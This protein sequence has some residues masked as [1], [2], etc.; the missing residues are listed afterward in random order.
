MPQALRSKL[1]NYALADGYNPIACQ[2]SSSLAFTAPTGL[3]VPAGRSITV[4]ASLYAFYGSSTLACADATGVTTSK[5]SVTRTGCSYTITAQATATGTASFTV[6]YT[7]AAQTLNGAFTVAIGPASNI[8]FTSPV[9]LIVATSASL[10]VYAADYATDGDYAISCAD[11]T[12]IDSKI[13]VQRTLCRYTVTAGTQLGRASFTVPYTSAG[14][15]TYNGTINIAIGPESR[16]LFTAPTGLKVARN[17]TLVIDA[18]RYVTEQNSV[19]TI[20]CLDAIGVDT[21]RLTAVSRSTSGNGCSYTIDPIDTLSPSL[22]GDT[23]FTIPYRSSSGRNARRTITV[24]IGPDSNLTF[25]DPGTFTVGRNRTLVIDAVRNRIIGENSAYTVSCGDATGV[26]AARMSVSRSGC[27]FTVDPV[28]TL[29]ATAPVG[30]PT[31]ATQGDTTFSVA[32]TSTGGAT[33]TGTFTVNIGPDSE[34]MGPA[35][36]PT[37]NIGRNHMLRINALDFDNN[38]AGDGTIDFTDGSYSILCEGPSEVETSKIDVTFSSTNSCLYTAEFFL[39]LGPAT[40]KVEF[41]STGGHRLTRT[42]TV[43]VGPQSVITFTAPTGL[44]VARDRTLEIDALDYVAERNPRTDSNPDGYTITCGDA[45]GLDNTK[46][47]SVTRS[48]SGDGC[49][50]TVD[51]VDTFVPASNSER[52]TTFSVPYTS[53][54]GD[55][56]TGTFTVNV[57]GNHD[58]DIVFAEPPPRNLYLV[59]GGSLTLNALDYDF[60]AKSDGGDDVADGGYTVSC[61]TITESPASALISLGAQSDGSCSI[62]I[63][64]GSGTGTATISVPYISSGGDIDS[65]TFTVAVSNIAYDAPTDLSVVVGRTIFVLVSSYV[66]D[67]SNTITCEA[68]PTGIDSNKLTSVVRPGGILAGCYFA[69]TAAL[70]AADEKA[71]FTVPV[72]SGGGSALDVIIQV[73]INPVSNISV[74]GTPA[75]LNVSRNRT[76]EIDALDFDGDGTDEVTDSSYT[77]SCGDATGVDA[78]K[79]AVSHTASSCAFTVD[80]VD[81]LDLSVTGNNSTTFTVP[82]TSS[83]GTTTSVTFTVNI[84]TDSTI[85]FTPPAS[86]PAIAASRTRTID[87]SSYAADGSYTISCGTITESSALISLGAQ[88]GCSI[89]ITAGSTPNQTANITIPYISSG[90]HTLSATL[91]LDVGAASSIIFTAPT[92]LKVGINRTQTIDALDYATD[93]GYTITCGTATGVDTTKLVS[94]VRDISGNGCGYT[95]TPISTLTQSQQGSASFTVP[96]TSDGGDTE[97]AMFSITVGPTSTITFTAPSALLV[98][99]NRTLVVDVSSYAVEANPTNYAISCG[100]AT[101]IDTVELQSVT[102]T[103]SSCTFTINPKNVAGSASFT[104]PYTSEG[105]HSVAGAISVTVGPD[106]N[107]VYT[108]PS[109]LTVGRNRT[110]VIDASDHFTEDSAYTVTCGDATGVDTYTDANS[111]VVPKMAVTHTGSSCIFTV[112][113]VDDLPDG[114]QGDATFSVAFTSTGGATASGTFTVNIGPDSTITYT[115]P[116]GLTVGRNRTLSI[117]ASGYVSEAD[118]NNTITCGDATSIDTTRLASVTR[119]ANTCSFTITP[120]STL[121]SSLQ[122]TNA[123][124]TV[125][126]ASSG[127]ATANGIIS[128]KVGPDSSMTFTAPT[129]LTVGR[130][131]TLVIDAL[132]AI[133][134]ENAAYTVSCADATSVDA[135]KMTVTRSSS[136]DGCSFTVDP[137]DSLVQAS[138]GDST[139]SVAFTST[140]GATASGTFTVNIGPDSTI[141]YTA[142]TGLTVGRNRTL[143]IDALAAISGENAAYTVSCADA[144]GVDASKMTV[145]RSSSGDGCSF[146]VDPVDSLATG[147]QG[148]TTFSVAFTSTGGATASGTFTVNIGPDS[149]ITYTAPTG[150]QIGRNQTL[151]IDASDYVSE[152]SNTY[153][154]SCSDASNLTGGRL[155]SVARTANTCDYTITPNTS[156]SSGAASFTITYTSNGGHSVAAVISLRVGPNSQI[157]LNTPPTS[158][159]GSLL[160]GRNR[161]LTIDASAYATETTGSGYTITCGDATS[162]DTTRLASVTR[163]ANTCSFTI[164]PISTLSSSLQTTNASFTVPYSSSGGATA[165]GIISVKVGPDSSMTFTAPTGL[166]VGRNRTLVIDA[167]AAISGENAAYT[168]S[169]ADA[170]S[171]DASKMTVTRSSSGDGCS[172]TVDPVDSLVQASQGDSTF[173]VAFTSTGGATAS[174]T[175]TVNI[176]P[177]STITYTAPTG[178]TVGRNRTLVI[179][180]LAA[181]SGENAAYTVSCADATGVDASKMAVTRSSSGDGCSFT[182]DPVDSLATGS[183]GDTTFSV[184]FTSTGGATASGTFTVNIGPDS[185]IVYTAPSGLTVGRNRT[186]VIDAS[187]HFTEDSAYTVTCGDATGVDTYTDANSDVVPKMAVT[188]TGSSCTFT[189]DPV[190]DLPD[191]SQGDATFS[192][193]FTSTGG[194]TA[195]G[196]FTVNIGPDS[197]ITYTAPTGLTVGRNRTLVIDALAAISGEN[198]AYTVSCADATG[199]DASK[200]TVTRSSSGDGCSFTVDPVDSL[201]TGSQGDTTFSVAFTSTGGATASGTFTVNIGPDS[202]ITYTAPTGLQIGRNQTLE[203]DASDYVSEAS[204]TYTIS[205]SDASNLT[206]GRLS[207]VA[208]TANTCDYTITP[209]TSASSGAASFTITY[210]SNGGHSVAAVISLRVGPNSQITLNT[211]PTSGAG[212]LL[213]GRNRTLTIDASAYATE[214]TGSGYTITCGDATSIDT[215]RLASVTRTANT[216][217]FTITPISTLSSSLQT[218]NASFTVPYSSSGGATANGIISVKVGPD[219]SMTFTAPT[220]LKVGRNRTLVIDASAAISGEDAAYAISCGDATG[221]DASKMTVAHI[222]SS[223]S[224][225]VDP[226]DSLVQASQGD[227]TFSV[228][229]SSTGGA[230]ASGTFTVNI[231]PDSTISYT[232]PGTL[233]VGRNRT[234][235]IDASSYVSDGS[236]TIACADATGVDTT[237]LTSV[238]RSADTCTF[239][240]DPVDALAQANQGDTTFSVVFTSE[241]GHIITRTITVNVGPDSALTFTAPGTFTLGRNRTLVIDALA[242][243]S[244]ENAAYTVTCADATGVDASKMTVTRSSGCS[245]TVDPVDSL[246]VGSQGDTTFSVAFSSTGGAT[247]SGTFTVNIGPDSNMTF[248]APT[249]LKVGRNRTLVIE[250]LDAISGENSAYT[251]TCADATG[252]DATKMTVT[253]SS[254][255][256]GCSFTV[257]PVDSLVVGSQGDTTFSVAYTSTGGATASGTYTVNIGPDSTITYTAPTG[258][259]IGRNL[260]LTI[261]ASDYVSE[262]GSSYTITC[263]DARNLTGGRL[264]SVART[265]NTCSYTITPNTSASTG[266]ASFTITYTSTGGHSL[267]AVIS[268]RVGP[269]SAITLNLPPTTGAGSLLT[270]RNRPLV[271]DAGSYASETSGS[272]YTI[273]C[274][275]ATSID[276]TRLASVT[277]TGSSCTFTVTPISTLSTSLQ[278]TAATFTVPYVS[279]GGATA[280]GTISVKIGPDSTMTFTAPTGLKVGRN[281]TLVIDASAAISGEDAAYA[282]SCGDA[283]GVDASKMTVAHIGSSCSFTVDPVDSLVQASQGDTTFSV[284]FSS[285]G[286]A[287]ASGTFTVNI[288]PD[289]TISYT[290]PGTLTVGR[291]RTLEIDASSYVSDGSYTIACA[292]ATGVDTTK[293]TSVSRSANTCTFTIDPVD[294]LAQANQGDTTFSVVFTSEG[295]HI[296]TRTITVNVGPDSA[297]TFTAPG[298]FT[299]GRN[300]TLVIDALAAISGENAAYTVTCGDATGVDASKMT[301]T[302][303]SGCSFTVDPV[304]SLATGSQGDTTFSVA[305][306][307]TGGATASGTFTVNIGPDS[308]MTFTAPTG[309]KVGRNRT[310]VIEALDAISGEDSAYTV[311]CADATGVD[312]TKM[313]VTRSSTGDGCSFTVD[314]VDSLAV[315]S[316]G[317]TT[318][319]VAYTSTGGAT[320]SGTYTVN[321]GP[322]STISYTAPTGLQIGRNLTLTIDA[323]DYVSEAG[324]SYTITCSDARNLTGGRLASV[325]R[326]ANTCSYT[327]TPNT[328]ASTGNA[329]FTIT[330]T[331]TGGH[332]IVRVISLRVGPNSAITFTAPPTTGAGRLLTGRN[333]A[334]VVDAG[335]YASETSGSGYTI[336][337]GDATSIDTTRLASVTHTGSSCTFTVTPISTL[338]TSLQTTNAAFTVPYT[339]SGGATANGIISVKIGPDSTMTFT[340]PTGLKVG[341]NRTLEID[342][343]A[344]ISGEDADYA[345]SCGDATGVDASKMEVAHIG[346]SC[347]FTVDPVNNLASGSQGDTTFSVPFTS[348]GGATASGTFTVNIGPDSTITYSTPGTLTVGRNRTLTIDAS[349]YVSEVSGSGHT[350]TCSDAAGV[351]STKLTSV[352]RTA[353]S[354]SFIITPVSSLSQ[355]LQGDTTFTIT[356]TSDGGHSITRTITVNVGPDSTIVFTPPASNLAI[357]ASR[358][359]TIDVSS[360]AADGSYTIT[361]GTITESDPDITLG[362]QTGCSIEITAGST[363]SQTADITIPYRSSGGHTLSSA[364]TLDVGAASSIVFTAPTSLKVGT[365]RTQTIDASDYATDGGY[366]ITCGTAT[367]TAANVPTTGTVALT[368]VVRDTSGN[369][370]GYTIT[371]TAT[372]GTATFTIP[373]T[374]AGGDTANGNISIT[375]GPP[376]TISYSSPGTLRVGRNQ[377]LEIDAS[378]Y[379]SDNSAYTITCADATGVVATRMAVTRTAN[380]CTF[381][382]DPVDALTPANQGVTTFTIPFTSDGGHSITGTVTVNIGPDSALT[383]TAPSTFTLGRNRTLVIDAL[384]AISGENA[385]YTVTCADATGVDADKITVTRSSSGDGCSFTVDPVDSLVQASQGDTTFSVAYTSTGGATASGTYT[386]NI[387]PDSTI[388]Y[389]AP[390]GLQIGRNLTL[391]IDASDY[392]TEAGSSYTITCSDARNL[393]GGRLASV[394]RT[395][396]TCDYTITPNTSASTGNASFTITYTS[397]GGHSLAAVISLRVGPN[398]AITLNLPPTTGAGSLLTGRNRPLVVDAGSYASETSGSGYTITCGDATSIDTTRLTS[399]THTGSS[400]SFTVTPIST[401]SSTL[402]ATNATFTV[403]Y[404]S[405]G[406]ATANGII[407]VKI[408]PD[409]TMTFTAPTGLK[410]GRN[411]T[412]EIDA[413][414]AISGEDAAYA[415]SCGDATSVDAS[416]MEVA[417]IG[418]SCTF[419]VDPVNNLASGSQGDTTFSVA[420]T[421]TGGATASGTFTVNIG[422]DSTITY[423]A[424]GTLTVGRNRTLTIDASDYVSEVSGSGHTITCS[425]AAGVDN[426]KLTSV[427]RTAN[428]CSFI[429]TPVSSLSQSLQGD[430]TFT[431]TF[432]SDGGHSITRTITVNVGPDSTI[433]FTPPAS[434]LAIAASRTRTIDVSGYA[435]DGSYTISCGSITESD[436]DITLGSQTGCSIEITAGSTPSQTA[437]ITIPYR[438]S[439]GH[440]LSSTLTLD[441]GA[442]STIVFTAPTGLKVGTN[443]TQTIDALD[444]AS[445]GGYTITC[446]IATNTAANVPTSGTVALTSVVRDAS[447]N[448]CGYTITP[449]ATQGTAT[450]TIPYTSAGG[451]TAN[452]NISITAGPPSTISYTAPGTLRVG[453]NLT[454]EI[455]ASGYVSDNSAYTI[456]CADATGVD[457]TKMTVTRTANSCTFT[458]DPVDS[459]APANQGS[460]SFSV[461]FTSDGG[462]SITRTITVNIG[463][464]S[465]LTFNDPG[466]FKLGRNRTLVIDALAATSGENAAYTVTCA[467]ATGV[468]ANKM[469]VTRSSTGDG[470]SFTVDP[471]DSLVQAS[472]GDTTFSVAFTSTGGA[473]ASGT[474]TINIGPDSTITYTA[475]TGL[476]VG[477]NRTLEID[478]SSYVSDNSAYTITCAD[479]TGVDATKMTVTRTANSCTFTIDPVDTL[480]QA[481]QGDTTFSITF[482]SDGGATATGSVTVNIGPDSTITFTAPTGLKTGRNRSL[483]LN[484]LDYV[485]YNSAYTVT[486]ADATAMDMTRIMGIARSSSGN[487]CAYTVT[488]ISTLAQSQQGD[489][490]FNV[491]FTSTGGATATGTFTINI[492]PDSTITFTAP[493]GLKVGRNR[494]LTINASDYVRETSGSGYTISCGDATGLHSSIDFIRRTGCAFTITP[495]STLTPAQQGDATFAIP[496]SS[497]GGHS[498]S[499][500]ITVN[501]GP[502]STITYTSPG[503]LRVAR[504]RTLTIDASS[505]VREVSGS[506]HTITCS[507]AAGADSNKMAVSRTANTCSFTIDPVDSLAPANQ[508]ATTFSITFTSDGG[509]SITRTITVNIGPDSALTFTD[510][511]TFTLGRNR[512]LVI[513]ALAATSGENAAYT[514][515][516]ADA[517]GVD[518]NKMTVTR[519]SSGDGCSFTVDPVDS[520]ATGS[521]GDTTFTVAFTSTG[522]ATASGTFTINIGPDSTITTNIPPATGANRLLVGRNLTLEIDASGYATEAS[523]TYTISCSDARNVHSRLT[524]V[525]R[526]ANTCSY[527]IDPVDSTSTGAATFVITFTS[528]GGHSVDRTITVNV[529][530]NSQ[531][532][533]TAPTGLK[534]GRN[535]TLEI[536]ALA[537]IS[538]ENSAY[539]VTCADATAIDMNRITG[540]ARSSSGN[541]CTYM[542]TPHSTLAQSL[543]GDATFNVVF[544]STGGATVTGTFTVNVGPDSTITYTAPTGLKVGRNRTLTIN[545]ASYA[546]DGSY[547]ISCGDATGLH[548]S[549]D[550]IRRTGCFFTITPISTLTPAQQGDAT[551]A[552]PFSSDGGHSISRTITV[553][554]GPDSEITYTAPTGSAIPIIPISTTRT[555]DVSSYAKEILNSGYTLS[556]GDASGIDSK[557]VSATHT[558]SSCSFEITTGSSQ[559]ASGFTTLYSS[560]GGHTRSARIPLQVGPASNIGF[561]APS[562]LSVNV[563]QTLTVDASDYV[564]DGPYSFTCA[565]AS[566]IS[567]SLASVLRATGTCRYTITPGSSTGTGTFSVAYTSSGGTTATQTISVTIN[568]QSRIS[569]TAPT[570]LTVAAGRAIT[571]DASSAVDTGYTVSCGAATNRHSRIASISRTGC[572]YRVN[573]G[574]TPGPA[575]FTIPFTSTGG[576]TLNVQIS[577]TIGPRSNIVFNAPTGLSVQIGQTLTID[578]SDYAADGTYTIT[579]ADAT[580]VSVLLA[581]VARTANT[582]NY[583]ITP[584]SSTGNSGF[585]VPYTSSGGATRN[586]RVNL[587]VTPTSNIVF[588][589]PTDLEIGAGSTRTINLSSYATDGPYSITC[590]NAT[591]AEPAKLTAIDRNGCDFRITAAAGA[592]QGD[593][594]FA[595]TYTSSGGDTH[596]ATFTIRIGPA[597]SIVFTAPDTNPVIRAT[598]TATIDVGQ[599]A[600]D[601]DYTITCGAASRVSSRIASISNNGCSYR[602]RAGVLLGQATFTVAYSSSGGDTLDAE[603]AITIIAPPSRPVAAAP[604]VSGADPNEVDLPVVEL[605]APE[606]DG[607]GLRWVTFT[608]DRGGTT[609]LHIRSAM[610]LSP[611]RS[612]YFWSTRTQSWTRITNINQRLSAGTI[613]AF[614]TE[615]AISEERIRASNLGGSTQQASL[616]QGWNLISLP[617]SVGELD[618]G[619]SLLDNSLIDCTNR[620]GVLIIAN[621]RP[622]SDTWHISLPCHPQLEARLIASEDASFDVLT[623]IEPGDFTFLF[624]QAPLGITV[625]WDEDTLRYLPS[626]RV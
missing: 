407:S 36:I 140:G 471:V 276:T 157:T 177:D 472:Q 192:V 359:R 81:S 85:V 45:T 310:L 368:S 314:P 427:T 341:R 28:D 444:Y 301:V 500:T 344:A 230:T 58:S 369:G 519:S 241:G 183:Q 318:F 593:T 452:G 558:G 18:S 10:T 478:A 564:T 606:P 579:C 302:R 466:T 135:S 475:P 136:G 426:T 217:S 386:I 617:A 453:R 309:L 231:G 614:Q 304:D 190:D 418:S 5:I 59:P 391:T 399:V 437:D 325:A 206:G 458:I 331:S 39:T 220:G 608:V 336:T 92:G 594:T 335:S 601:G 316:Q 103:G 532:T 114:S 534:V 401:L 613:V 410:V 497:D 540:I 3:Q 411:R 298:T 578:A 188:H 449:T 592:A 19:F 443:R 209:N 307:S 553:N 87:V 423:T 91:T 367:N 326:T 332:S 66:S 514:V 589:A 397:T 158:G 461:V 262:A 285:T 88:N 591:A 460:T 128:V 214:T 242:A 312:A 226:V 180:A 587:A 299:L 121:S 77:I 46:L 167:L 1:G 268:L 615:G 228:A 518:A 545:A 264:T 539:T 538:G 598:T 610:G 57:G 146:T 31:A 495:I 72:T 487:G 520:L 170:T 340:A 186:L 130:N 189:V 381:T 470:C 99:K 120:I 338:S 111:D 509:H 526:T 525:A 479:A 356:F 14:G 473:T 117:D 385:A 159:A 339:S 35:T 491:V 123:T 533:F 297:L 22:Q 284:A 574:G 445:D 582:C 597:S 150:L 172:F 122:T 48:S 609:G 513:D 626:T 156:A 222:G 573:A 80:P 270:G 293:L 465:A 201:A 353:N 282:I 394:A 24:N 459:L 283:T 600:E 607:L 404:T 246:V 116:T 530:P 618:S 265:A 129:G 179:D 546:S 237:K 450:F 590:G 144:T 63:T 560:T 109:G 232:D 78:N 13:T 193:A 362:A 17:F 498:I 388:T 152:A 21:T 89:E 166:T 30:D 355:S 141:T 612:I 447:G 145:T 624:Y 419:T 327:I 194:A 556:C 151:E 249:G 308:S 603:I 566:S 289:S 56:A 343:S 258:L 421:S 52:A 541:G 334:L 323:S 138:Q 441:V 313:T 575:S 510:P 53:S 398:S 213:T 229:F 476:K 516:C 215:T 584:G 254:T 182:V 527:T 522:G 492:G 561:S 322:D 98:A 588:I 602:I 493:T 133:S 521:Q 247:A 502:D 251:V 273:S 412:L 290:S 203:I 303:S 49:T 227:T 161:T 320:A 413:A 196:T 535:R 467:D 20:S 171:V 400:C 483:T 486:C 267:A 348:T 477:R 474:F 544:T 257:D 255:G 489:A 148:D 175:F 531:I 317:D 84:S 173:S 34:I 143:V 278:T 164:T 176:G 153:T 382:I 71:T 501:I 448:G 221:V 346:S 16:V 490:T 199:V 387:G 163:T 207:S 550:F 11:A 15:N 599:Y 62:E 73:K 568:P 352:T 96:L 321:I 275:D 438:S 380:S 330:Y 244:G 511:G 70:T 393:T 55:T 365:N 102:H 118:S 197:T 260:T 432:T 195:S 149:T 469:T 243:I 208:R 567:S 499:R 604:T 95:I 392:A 485:T 605:E 350:I 38:G 165:N 366:T 67:G 296:I 37:F 361:C 256:D 415:I 577:I 455:D 565:D 184:A 563:G 420:F 456:T 557:L 324:S 33:A 90:G 292:D 266:N 494:T 160:T 395:A 154:I 439:G 422:P 115:A 436:P 536:K 223:C 622:G 68:A 416:K 64:A 295:G 621:Q 281:R 583:T 529:G 616:G 252:V 430:T 555:I 311:T 619:N 481:N 107:I 396:N 409:S 360:Y 581:S 142:P 126:Y 269:N 259:Q 424:P 383:F 372:Q 263:S 572:S 274:G 137:V 155:S 482:T 97:N 288:G 108:A 216:C 168:V 205:C 198:A 623:A 357:A 333:R 291:N 523:N 74:S 200:M 503:T 440:T 250:A 434:N 76:L 235:E 349:D 347:S 547:T 384:A 496:F 240:I 504:N 506:G 224:F 552:I 435:A 50:F 508:G 389:N 611:S 112:D 280:T 127:G 319:S 294:A 12:G 569:F 234:L 551:F 358:T 446:G 60:N 75:V 429:I 554:I 595:F 204:N 43:N 548:T 238:S 363:P 212:S 44:E 236:Y 329:S 187:D 185:T 454:L 625:N 178:L 29:P 7:A 82:Y 32:Y 9:G 287:T 596:D 6:P 277:H 61:G 433:V 210:T 225:T 79:I 42:F 139:F 507:D 562:G 233:T 23:T 93:G 586:G 585:T 373:Y 484:A 408:G 100:D 425:D 8:V 219:S 463:P 537:A 542:V 125:P 41:V 543:Q 457:A 132:A 378:G 451:D 462:H 239:T 342:A 27:S 468:D 25:T 375:V 134:G 51:P 417:H 442:A 253:R 351:D 211:P 169:C 620:T 202:T 4:D 65:K 364:L 405:S 377:T 376:S 428:T 354:C 26:D 570:G 110:L 261:D 345:I 517:T 101:S 505:Y 580:G 83:G 576:A 571:V 431:I 300:R 370:C 119:T 390:T 86:N 191:G 328:S 47:T 559:G 248:T 147:S 306:T 181:I 480:A 286:G 524:S 406:G 374:S 402:Q 105:G 40:F 94:V 515:T 245:F 113:P 488:P 54:G 528:T 512:T 2:R 272:G 305:F 106:S 279:S 218:T 69:V 271:V 337:C 371:P 464:D 174:G 104:V 379:V 131:R 124:F 403:P 549:I 162:I 414:A 315:G